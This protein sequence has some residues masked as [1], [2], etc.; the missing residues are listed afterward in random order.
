M[1]QDSN[2]VVRDGPYLANR[3]AIVEVGH[4]TAYTEPEA[5]QHPLYG[6]TFLLHPHGARRFYAWLGRLTAYRW[7]TAIPAIIAQFAECIMSS[8]LLRHV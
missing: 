7:R 1:L 4:R 6:G 3:I 8:T 2:S 5:S